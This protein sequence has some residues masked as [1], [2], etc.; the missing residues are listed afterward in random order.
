[1]VRNRVEDVDL[2]LFDQLK[3]GDILFIDNSHTVFMNSDTAVVF[4]DI[5][6]RLKLGVVVHTHDIFDFRLELDK[7]NS[8]KLF[9]Q[10]SIYKSIA[11]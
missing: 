3:S 6:P 8:P 7:S 10:S 2:A 9:N 5:L 1:M 4:L 11:L